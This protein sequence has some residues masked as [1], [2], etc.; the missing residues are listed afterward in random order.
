MKPSAEDISYLKI[1]RQEW[2]NNLNSVLSINKSFKS[3]Q[4][5]VKN[6]DN[7]YGMINVNSS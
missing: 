2:N 6:E 5:N 7:K 4:P 1:F 3:I